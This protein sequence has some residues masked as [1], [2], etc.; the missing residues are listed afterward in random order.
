M[1]HLDIDSLRSA[2]AFGSPREGVGA[3]DA[4]E[5]LPPTDQQLLGEYVANRSEGA[6]AQL[7]ARHAGLVYSA[8]LRQTLNETSAEEITQAV[9]IILARKASS[10]CR[11]TLLE[12][13]LFRAVRYAVMDARKIEAR[14]NRREHEA[15][16]MYSTAAGEETESA[17]MHM[18][19]LIDEALASLSAKDRHAILLRFFE[20]KS[21]RH[22]GEKVG[23]NENAARLRVVRAL[24]KLR[25]FFQKR[26]VIVSSGLLSSALLVHSSQAV[27][28]GLVSSVMGVVASGQCSA[29]LALLIRAILRRIWWRTWPIWVSGFGIAV[30]LVVIVTAFVLP[31]RDAV[32]AQVRAVAM[33]VDNAISFDDPDI[34]LA[35]IHFRNPEEEQFKP[36]L[37]AFIRAAVGLRRQVRETFDAQP[38]RMEIWLWTLEQLFQGQPRRGQTNIPPDRIV[39]DLFQPYLVV[40]AKVG[41]EWKWDFFASFPPDVA[42][43][44]MKALRERTTLCERVTRQI[45]EGEIT[46][47]D[48]ALAQIRTRS[49]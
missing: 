30:L 15:A 1:K 7:V 11:E 26:G 38:A 29:E 42:Q 40:V 45:R 13:W 27:P 49:N 9:F 33:A 23:S 48:Q 4:V 17:W 34:L 5:P 3:E 22:I 24:E 31:D 10:L 35:H 39:D 46:N 25:R 47:A 8:A 20:E 2:S 28:P 21:F 37:S 19:P 36:V 12:G 18:A 14:R 41:R 16:Q 6:F 43:E 32:R 44:Q